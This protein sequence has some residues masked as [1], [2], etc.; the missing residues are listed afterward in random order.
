MK[1]IFKEIGQHV[2]KGIGFTIPF[3]VLF[4]VIS[5]IENAGY[6][7]FSIVLGDYVFYVLVPILVG[8]IGHSI[9]PYKGLVPGFIVG[10]FVASFE[11]GYLGGMI[12]GLGV[13]YLVKISIEQVKVKNT[14][15]RLFIDYIVVGGYVT[16]I[17]I[18]VMSLLFRPVIL[19]LLNQV[20]LF[21]SGISITEVL[22][23]VIV[24]TSLTVVD[25]G[26]PF[27][28]LAYSFII[29]FYTDG[30][31]EVIG[32]VLLGVIVPPLSVFVG[33]KLLKRKFNDQDRKSSKIALIG[34]LFGMTEGALAVGFR[35]PHKMIPILLIGSLF[36]S[37][38]ATLFK[39]ENSALLI[40]IPGYLTVSNIFV[41]TGSIFIGVFTCFAL[42][43]FLLKDQTDIA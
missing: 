30:L 4:S 19:Y 3:I 18:I 13:G 14:K 12:A 27:N 38:F 8:F 17:N 31:Y 34:G 11:L 41:Y 2:V 28:K 10:Y 20:E 26:G 40:G 22:F 16:V 36:A 37:V 29:Q 23:L 9:V 42:F 5:A 21:V 35:R 33:L 1:K 24:I 32:P 7:S 25:L 39:L 6:I 43:V 15:L